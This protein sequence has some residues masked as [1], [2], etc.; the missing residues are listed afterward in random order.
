M[1]GNRPER[2]LDPKGFTVAFEQLTG[3]PLSVRWV[4]HACRVGRINA[5]G[6]GRHFIPPAEVARV[7]EEM[8]LLAR[9]PAR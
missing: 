7:A 3:I 8:G 1:A 4:Q 6:L 9:E 2:P 5:R